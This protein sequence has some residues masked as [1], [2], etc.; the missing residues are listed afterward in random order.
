MRAARVLRGA[1]LTYR[2][3][4]RLLVA[5]AGSIG[6]ACGGTDPIQL[7]SSYTVSTIEGDPPPRLIGATVECDVSVGGGHLTI[8]TARNFELGLDVLTDCSRG[9]GST[10]EATYGYTGTA[11]VDGRRVVFHTATGSGPLVFEGQA[12]GATHLEVVVPGLVPTAEHVA[13]EF[14]AE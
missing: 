3:A 8:G 7:A 13:V 2:G 4:V 1:R 11:E 10:S 5:L 14:E 9:G 6:A 12:T